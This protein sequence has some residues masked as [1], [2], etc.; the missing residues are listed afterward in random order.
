[1]KKIN[2]AKVNEPFY[3]LRTQLILYY[4]AISFAVLV[5]GAYFSYM[6]ILGVLK[7]NNEKYFLQQLSQVDYNI[8]NVFNEIDRLSKI[9]IMSEDV[10]KFLQDNYNTD[11][12]SELETKKSISN[13]ISQC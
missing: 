12:F 10:Q 8:Q 11:E 2:R 3:S 13:R 4:T 6:Y 9:F 1:M 5:I 7:K